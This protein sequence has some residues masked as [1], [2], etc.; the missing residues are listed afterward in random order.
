MTK[1]A[2]AAL[3]CFAL[4]ALPAAVAAQPACAGTIADD[5]TVVLGEV[6]GTGHLGICVRRPT[7]AIAFYD[8]PTCNLATP[9]GYVL[10]FS[11]SGLFG[12]TTAIAPLLIS[13]DCAG[14]WVDP[15]LPG[16]QFG[17]WFTGYAGADKAFGTPHRDYLHGNTYVAWAPDGASDTLCGY[18]DDDVLVGDLEAVP[19][20]PLRACLNGGINIAGGDTCHNGNHNSCETATGF[21]V[22]IGFD[23]GCGIGP[24]QIW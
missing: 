7:G 6:R 9:I 19:A 16:F 13:V 22:P 12:G 1:L 20:G 18:D 17:L 3:F 5:G 11:S 15:F 2:S 4:A 10:R 8:V 21:G 14:T 23:C 24:P